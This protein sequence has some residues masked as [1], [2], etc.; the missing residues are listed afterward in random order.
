MKI[1]YNEVLSEKN[2]LQDEYS[3]EMIKVNKIK[4]ERA[5][6]AKAFQQ[7][8]TN[9]AN[10]MKMN[11]IPH[12]SSNSNDQRTFSNHQSPVVDNNN[13]QQQFQNQMIPSLQNNLSPSPEHSN[14]QPY[15]P[16]MGQNLPNMQMQNEFIPNQVNSQPS[17]IDK[18]FTY[19]N[20]QNDNIQQQQ[21][22]M[23]NSTNQVQ[24]NSIH[25]NPMSPE[26]YKVDDNA[27]DH[28]PFQSNEIIIEPPTNPSLPQVPISQ[29]TN[30][31]NSS[32]VI[33]NDY[34]FDNNAQFNNKPP[35]DNFAF[36]DMGMQNNDVI[37]P[38]LNEFD[39]SGKFNDNDNNFQANKDNNFQINNTNNEQIHKTIPNP[40][41]LESPANQAYP[42]FESITKA[43]GTNSQQ[44]QSNPFQQQNENKKNDFDFYNQDQKF[45]GNAFEDF[46]QKEG[47]KNFEI[48]DKNIK[49]DDWNF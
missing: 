23:P 9:P 37:I 42:S 48:N 21:Q 17:N 34:N 25:S 49:E 2:K 7:A 1:S 29:N 40:D 18:D 36:N 46:A 20:Q 19:I 10:Q 45:E 6:K 38:G 43:D 11:P 27:F 8:D 5:D 15:I 14:N 12:Y 30:V 31:P 16:Q 39:F 44:V 41:V 28:P 3:K 22:I 13:Q 4:Q 26:Q 32:N 35:S 24:T 33:N 47:N